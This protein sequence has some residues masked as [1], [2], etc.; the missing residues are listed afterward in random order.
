MFRPLIC[1]LL[2]TLFS[3]TIR[4][5]R[6]NGGD[7][8]TRDGKL[9]RN[10]DEAWN[11]LNSPAV[12]QLHKSI[13]G[14]SQVAKEESEWQQPKRIKYEAGV[15]D[16]RQQMKAENGMAIL[17]A[18]QSRIINCLPHHRNTLSGFFG[19]I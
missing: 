6:Y 19:Q 11:H 7:N 18:T 9:F 14:Y 5:Q 12:S 13:I 4:A 8:K 17:P 3:G 16:F 1:A 2:F 15:A 10:G